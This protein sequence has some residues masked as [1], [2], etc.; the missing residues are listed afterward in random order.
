MSYRTSPI[1]VTMYQSQDGSLWSSEAKAAERNDLLWACE[2]AL[3][4][5][6]PRPA[7]DFRGYV[8]QDKSEVLRAKAS[9]LHIADRDGHLSKHWD[10][11]D[12]ERVASRG[13]MFRILTDE[14]G[15]ISK[16][17]SRIACIDDKYREWVQQWYCDHPEDNE[18]VCVG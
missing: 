14:D 2:D 7:T 6:K 8:Q 1:A 10:I 18:L 3:G 5:L 15:P 13:V 4:R 16:A 12:P 17:W 9:I 11:S